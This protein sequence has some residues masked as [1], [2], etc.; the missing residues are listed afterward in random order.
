MIPTPRSRTA[1]TWLA[2]AALVLAVAAPAFAAAPAPEAQSP[3]S[4]LSH[5][6]D[7]LTHLGPGT[8]PGVESAR[9][10]STAAPDM[11][12]NGVEAVPSIGP[13]PTLHYAAG[14]DDDGEAAPDMDPDG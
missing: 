4:F 6:I 13:D 5:L 12:P 8:Q 7:W 14:T 2:A 3:S 1:F 10:T 11:D 9:G